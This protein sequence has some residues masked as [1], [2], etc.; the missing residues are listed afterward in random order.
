MTVEEL[1]KSLSGRM[2]TMTDE[3]LRIG[4]VIDKLENYDEVTV[5]N[6]DG[7]E[8]SQPRQQFI[9]WGYDYGKP[10]GI[11][12]QKLETLRALFDSKIED[13]N[14]EKQQDTKEKTLDRAWK[15]GTRVGLAL[16]FLVF[17][18]KFFNWE[19]V[20]QLMK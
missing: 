1:Y 4:K 17:I 2:D 10:G 18:V 8:H 19:T 5:T 6:G 15:W 12:D 3:L 13:L 11:A 14:P 7:K 20:F 9:Q 16:L